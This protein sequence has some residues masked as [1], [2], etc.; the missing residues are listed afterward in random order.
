MT[1]SKSTP[2][3]DRE[4]EELK[5]QI[6]TIQHDNDSYKLEIK[7]L[8]EATKGCNVVLKVSYHLV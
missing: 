2:E 3:E 7:E 5:Q 6:E 8:K 1:T 4:I